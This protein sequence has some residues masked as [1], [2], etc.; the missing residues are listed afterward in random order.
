MMATTIAYLEELV[1]PDRHGCRALLANTVIRGHGEGGSKQFI[2][3]PL[4][5]ANDGKLTR[6]VVMVR[7]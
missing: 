3:F 6:T 7:F 4:G 5:R 2:V 1:C